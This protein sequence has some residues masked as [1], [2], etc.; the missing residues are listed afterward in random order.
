MT[1]TTLHPSKKVIFIS[2]GLSP[3]SA[4]LLKLQAAGHEVIGE[5][6]IR[7][8]RIRF[9]HTPP[10]K[11]IFFSSK[12]AIRHFFEQNPEIGADVKFGVMSRSSADLLLT[13]GKQADFTGEGV[14]T[15]Q[16]AKDFAV[17]VKD[18]TVLLPQAIDSLQTIQ[19]QLSFTN[20]CFNLFVYKTTLRT[21][22]EISPANVLVFTSPSNVQAYYEKYKA[23]DNQK[24]IA[25]GTT[26][27]ARLKAYNIK[28]VLM[29]AIFTEEGLLELVY[30]LN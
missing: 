20:N 16:I 4:V 26:T 18:E 25:M 27:A 15:T 19:K 28:E 12:N 11:W 9:T 3:Q 17:C 8:S 22:F 2:R 6:L 13:Y 29:P 23:D 30:N 14:D 10:S 7:I 21:D 1:Q 24:V 5:S